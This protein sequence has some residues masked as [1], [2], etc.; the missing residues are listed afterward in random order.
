MLHTKEIVTNAIKNASSVSVLS[1]E[2]ETFEKVNEPLRDAIVKAVVETNCDFHLS[3]LDKA[4][5]YELKV[6][7]LDFPLKEGESAY[8]A[9]EADTLDWVANTLIIDAFRIYIDTCELVNDTNAIN[10]D[11]V[12]ARAVSI[13]FGNHGKL[14]KS[15]IED[16]ARLEKEGK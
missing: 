13:M 12:A 6:M 16:K 14:N 10:L 7:A 11:A 8:T 5:E 2:Q 15:I 1:E 3:Q 9:E 4:V